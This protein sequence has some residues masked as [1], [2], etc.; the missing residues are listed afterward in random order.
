MRRIQFISAM[1]II[2][3]LCGVAGAEG[4]WFPAHA[5]CGSATA[6]VFD[7]G[8]PLHSEGCIT[9]PSE[10]FIALGPSDFTQ[11]GSMGASA[12]ASTES[13][14]FAF[15][16]HLSVAVRLRAA[17][18]PSLFPGGDNPGGE[19][20]A[21]LFSVIEFIMPVDELAWD[22]SLLID[23]DVPFFEGSTLVTVENV[24]QSQTLLT[25]T[26][27]T[28]I[29]HTTLQGSAGDLIR[30]TSDMSGAGSMGPGSG[31]EYVSW[32][33][34]VFLPEPHTWVLLAIAIL[35]VPRR[36]RNA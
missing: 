30:I 11:P 15:V 17:Y 33:T 7:G 3:P 36:T 6:N 31:K 27:N 14:V 16:D 13:S 19:A 29:V 25:L 2:G 22:Y 12:S 35:A 5:F 4:I 23:E 21:D 9:D 20:E 10:P 8:P 1:A 28:N 32:L 26:E 18:S 24:T 34:M